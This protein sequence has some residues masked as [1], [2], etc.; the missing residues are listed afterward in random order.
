MIVSGCTNIY[1]NNYDPN[2]TINDGSCVFQS[3]CTL[4]YADNYDP[5]AVIDDGSCYCG[6]SI[7]L[8]ELSPSGLTLDHSS[9][10]T[11]QW[12]L[13]FDM[14]LQLDCGGILDFHRTHSISIS[15]IVT[16]V[17]YS[18]VTIGTGD[19]ISEIPLYQNTLNNSVSITGNT[20]SCFAVGEILKSE[21]GLGCLDISFSTPKW[22][23]HEVLLGANN[24]VFDIGI[25]LKGLPFAHTVLLDN[26]EL[27]AIC[28]SGYTETTFVPQE[29]GFDIEKE[30]SPNG[31]IGADRS[32]FISNEYIFRLN[33]QKYIALDVV[34][35]FN[36]KK[37]FLNN[38]L[39]RHLTLEKIDQMS[40]S[41]RQCLYRFYLEH[42]SSKGLTPS[43][44]QDIYNSIDPNWYQLI[45]SFIPS[46]LQ[47]DA[48]L[49]YYGNSMFNP[50]LHPYNN[51]GCIDH[52][53]V[54]VETICDG[55]VLEYKEACDENSLLSN[56]FLCL[57]SNNGSFLTRN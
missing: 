54:Y 17:S 55:C 24:E 2:A 3:G 5:S 13:A 10:E 37:F 4:D 38:D 31:L 51:E 19:S 43:Y 20:D 35:F 40:L 29:F 57:L 25:K 52:D 7:L 32:L 16:G 6:E 26:I 33:P 30:M 21:N 45:N 15:D 8:L 49:W 36:N 46:G 39:Y 18:F 50:Q 27:N 56:N 22:L 14:L 12:L 44:V 23:H 48:T 1:A 9:G 47:R 53:E 41:Q 11:C 34:E 28:E 42:C